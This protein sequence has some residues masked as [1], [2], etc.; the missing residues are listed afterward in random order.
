MPLDRLMSGRCCC[1][2]GHPLTLHLSRPSCCASQG[3]NLEAGAANSRLDPPLLLAIGGGHVPSARALLRARA[4]ARARVFGSGLTALQLAVSTSQHLMVDALLEAGVGVAGGGPKGGTPL[5]LACSQRLPS[6]KVIKL[7]LGHGAQP[8][9]PDARGRR[10]LQLLPTV[11]EPSPD[12]A[13]VQAEIEQLTAVCEVPC[14]RFDLAAAD[15]TSR[16]LIPWRV[17]PPPSNQPIYRRF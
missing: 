12:S 7:L 9:A 15:S 11:E 16:L 6:A 2:E 13:P 8:N 3:A 4:D 1:D 14:R 17:I 5:Q 10:P